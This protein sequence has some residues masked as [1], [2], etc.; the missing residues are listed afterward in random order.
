M[1]AARASCNPSIAYLVCITD[2]T[3]ETTPKKHSQDQ[4]RY[5]EPEGIVLELISPILDKLS[6]PRR[7]RLEFPIDLS[8]AIMPIVEIR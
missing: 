6:P 4:Y 5:G 8:E 2:V 1:A 3:A 7:C